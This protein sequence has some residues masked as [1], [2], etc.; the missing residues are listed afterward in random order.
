MAEISLFFIQIPISGIG[1]LAHTG[2]RSK[3][4]IGLPSVLLATFNNVLTPYLL[5]RDKLPHLTETKLGLSQ[6]WSYCHDCYLLLC[7][8]ALKDDSFPLI[9]M[10]DFHQVRHTFPP[11][12]Q[13]YLM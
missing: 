3:S 11:K 5:T 9:G 1:I 8:S 12:K 6:K 7:V 4:R 2:Y 10:G 13:T